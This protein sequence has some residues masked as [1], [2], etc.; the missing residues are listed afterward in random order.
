MTEVQGSNTN[1]FNMALTLNLDP[2]TYK[3]TTYFIPTLNILDS[4]S[5]NKMLSDIFYISRNPSDINNVRV[6]S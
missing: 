1:I 2:V 6:L 4:Y 5:E 3:L